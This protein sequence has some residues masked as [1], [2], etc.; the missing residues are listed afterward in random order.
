MTEEASMD[1]M[2]K[3]RSEVALSPQH[4]T[5]D[6]RSAKS[7]PQTQTPNYLHLDPGSQRR[8]S[9]ITAKSLGLCLA[10][11]VAFVAVR[12]HIRYDIKQ[13]Y[14]LYSSGSDPHRNIYYN[15][16]PG[17]V[18]EEDAFVK[19]LIGRKGELGG[20]FDLRAT[21]WVKDNGTPSQNRGN[22]ETIIFTDTVFRGVTLRDNRL[23]TEIQLQ[24]PTQIL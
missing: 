6:V 9:G 3:L 8:A 2:Q 13:L 18:P 15:P 22:S 10:L 20:V 11:L 4:S 17:V 1:A 21:V 7:V 14:K 5:D 16:K 19:P 23:R 24:I 12:I